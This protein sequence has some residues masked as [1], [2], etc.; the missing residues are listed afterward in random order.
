MRRQF[1]KLSYIRIDCPSG[2][3]VSNA[4][5]RK[6]HWVQG[7]LTHLE[8]LLAIYVVTDSLLHGDMVSVLAL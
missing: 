6:F 3:L 5:M 8:D 1:A 7:L 4:K 2:L